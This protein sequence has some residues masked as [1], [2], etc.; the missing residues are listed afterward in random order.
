MLYF[1]GDLKRL[2]L[3]FLIVGCA[4][5]GGCKSPANQADAANGAAAK[6]ARNAQRS[7]EDAS[8]QARGDESSGAGASD[9]QRAKTRSKDG[10]TAE[11]GETK[12]N[13]EGGDPSI[14]HPPVHAGKA[15][16]RIIETKTVST[17]TPTPNRPIDRPLDPSGHPLES[18]TPGG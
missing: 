12:E 13:L 14:F 8:S 15:R 2:V 11:E 7:A 5:G 4:F 16:E 3:F 1:L 17:P 10:E 18:P 6:K 9:Y